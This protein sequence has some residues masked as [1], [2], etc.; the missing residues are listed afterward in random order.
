MW[1]RALTTVSCEIQKCSETL[2][3]FY[4]AFDVKSS[5]GYT[6][7]RI[8]P[9]SSSSSFEHFPDR[10]PKRRKQ[11]LYFDDHG[12]HFTRKNA[13]F[14]AR[15]S[16]Q[17]WIHAFPRWHDGEN[18]DHANCIFQLCSGAVSVRVK[19]SSRGSLVHILPCKLD[20][21]NPKPHWI[22]Q[23]FEDCS[24]E[25]VLSLQSR[26]HV[27]VRTRPHKSKGAPWVFTIFHVKSRSR[28]SLVRILPYEFDHKLLQ[29]PHFS[30]FL[31]E[32]ELP[33]QY[34]AHFADLIFQKCSETLNFFKHFQVQSELSQQS[35]AA[36]ARFV[37]NF[38]RSRPATSE[39]ETLLRRPQKPLYP[40]KHRV[41]RQGFSSLNSRVPA[42]LLDDDV[43]DMILWLTWWWE[44]CPWQSSVTR[45]LS[46]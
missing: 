13:G 45:K 31:C 28:Y 36:R 38:C 2:N 11:R 5:S 33:L 15:V 29:M 37:E 24:C 41:S 43:V 20:H 16:F 8:L 21:T 14:H 17:A 44:C 27:A 4:V 34:R 42:Q 3:L 6:L 10:G 12:S 26:A 18:S 46:S 39:T 22:P 9:T 23:F 19:S 40:Q 35:C 1:D 25:I 30:R 32:T 7:V